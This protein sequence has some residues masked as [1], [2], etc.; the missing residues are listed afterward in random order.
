MKCSLSSVTLFEPLVLW[1]RT[2]SSP[3][4]KPFLFQTFR[5]SASPLNIA[6]RLSRLEVPMLAYL[7]VV[8]LFSLCFSPFGDYAP[9]TDRLPSPA[10]VL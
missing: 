7:P 6:L 4:D 3:T 2:T 1:L 10:P 9:R 8:V 5:S